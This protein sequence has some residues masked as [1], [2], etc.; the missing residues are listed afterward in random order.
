M[1]RTT[2]A[3]A[4]QGQPDF[5]L[6]YDAQAV[7]DTDVQWLIQCL[8]ESVRSGKRY[9]PGQTLQAGWAD[10]RIEDAEGDYLT[11]L[12]PDWSGV[13]PIR[14][15]RGVT[16]ALVD[17]RR[18]RDIADSVGLSGQLAMP[19]ISESGIVCTQLASRTCG[20]MEREGPEG[21][22]SGWFFGCDDPEHDHSSPSALKRESLYVTGCDVPG[23]VQFCA[24]PPGVRISFG[25]PENISIRLGSQDL[26]VRPGSY[27]DKLRLVS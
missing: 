8:E 12:E 7:I 23:I 17:L 22:D 5:L 18:Q 1:N 11:L 3:C 15:V 19:R 4:V 13:L 27:L 16:R 26:A 21:R 9:E 10:L 20:V 2:T 25:G 14:Y 24:L 6:E